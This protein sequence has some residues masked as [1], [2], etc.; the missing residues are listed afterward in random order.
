MYVTLMTLAALGWLSQDPGKSGNAESVIVRTLD[1]ET[2]RGKS[3][4]VGE[5]AVVLRGPEDAETEM[6]LAKVIGVDFRRDPVKLSAK[7]FLLLRLVDGTTLKC[8]RVGFQEK[9]LTARLFN[10][11]NVKVPMRSV[12]WLL[13]DAH[14]KDNRAEFEEIV[15]Q[16]PTL[17]QLRLLSRDGKRINTFEGVITGANAT[18]DKLLFKLDDETIPV[19]MSRVRGFFLSNQAT[20][21]EQAATCRFYDRFGNVF[22]AK[23]VATAEDR[24]MFTLGVGI[25]LSLPMDSVQRFD[26]SLGKLAY[27]SDLEPVRHEHMGVFSDLW[28]FRRDR[29]LMGGALSLGGRTY[30]KGLAVSSRTVLEYDVTGYRT[31]SCLLGIDDWVGGPAH[32]VVRFHGDGRELLTATVVSRSKPQEVE[33][34]IEG[35]RRLRITVDYGEDFDRGDHVD[36]VEAKVTK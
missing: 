15:E 10:G 27:L 23:S 3:V 30:T 19:T 29:S 26:F 11:L 31:F 6:P 32:A 16:R 14:D 22:V 5:S 21:E 25:P 2:H 35:I 9:E 28:H 36:L 8:V 33:L 1:G 24:V 18:G 4:T 20:E 7:E 34:Q 12:A 13:C 17:D